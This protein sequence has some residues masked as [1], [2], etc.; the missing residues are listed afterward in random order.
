MVEFSGC[1]ASV[2]RTKFFSS[3]L[4]KACVVCVHAVRL[5]NAPSWLRPG[6]VFLF[7]TIAGKPAIANIVTA[8]QTL[9]QGGAWCR[10]HCHVAPSVRLSVFLTVTLCLF[11]AGTECE[12]VCRIQDVTAQCA[13]AHQTSCIH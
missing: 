8:G 9:L 6:S 3:F 11:V 10:G 13:T 5:I 4:R 1:Q 7:D 2:T 12:I